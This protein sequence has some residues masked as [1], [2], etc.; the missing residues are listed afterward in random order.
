[1]SDGVG[2]NRLGLRNP[3]FGSASDA[4]NYKGRICCAQRCSTC[5]QA[6]VLYEHAGSEYC[7]TWPLAMNGIDE[8]GHGMSIQKSF[9]WTHKNSYVLLFS[10]CKFL[11]SYFSMALA[12]T[13]IFIKKLLL[14]KDFKFGFL[15]K[16]CRVVRY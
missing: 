13:T 5:F 11:H 12:F 15:A 7:P 2:V 8:S 9:M 6:G 4:V 1:M 14:F 3:V 10:L 16:K